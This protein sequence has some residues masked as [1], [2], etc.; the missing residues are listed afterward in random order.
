M[1]QRL[2]ILLVLVLMASA[3]ASKPNTNP[4][5]DP[6]RSAR[7]QTAIVL[8]SVTAGIQ[9]TIA[10]QKEG[11]ITADEDRTVLGVLSKVNNGAVFINRRLQAV[12]SL[13]AGTRAELSSLLKQVFDGLQDA[14]NRGLLGIKNALAKQRLDGILQT[15][16]I[17][18]DALKP[19]FGGN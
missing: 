3:C 16:T 18:L 12:T 19:I 6:L 11:L 2:S 4:A 1:K 17:A 15:I 7:I 8:D 9:A 13:S 5:I 10:L 14:N